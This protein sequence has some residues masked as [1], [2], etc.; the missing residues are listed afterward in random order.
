MVLSVLKKLIIL[1]KSNQLVLCHTK[2]LQDV[3]L[4][5]I[6]EEFVISNPFA[7]NL[8][9][10]K[11]WI[12]VF[13]SLGKAHVRINGFHDVPWVTDTYP[14]DTPNSALLVEKISTSDFQIS[15][16]NLCQTYSLALTVVS[17]PTWTNLEIKIN[18]TFPL[19]S[20][21]TNSIVGQYNSTDITIALLPVTT[22]EFIIL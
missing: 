16:R 1:R 3:T 20:L 22:Q 5:L 17:Q 9:L 21:D 19:R 14:T 7:D 13:F 2:F 4:K 15:P 6:L 18:L 12:H 10:V 8:I 11:Y